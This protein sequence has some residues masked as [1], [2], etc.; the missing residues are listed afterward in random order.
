MPDNHRPQLDEGGET[1]DPKARGG[2]DFASQ[3]AQRLVVSNFF[4]AECHGTAARFFSNVHIFVGALAAGLAAVS[5]GTAFTG[6]TTLAGT[7]GLLSAASAGLLTALRPD[8]RSLCTG[9]RPQ[10]ISK[11]PTTSTCHLVSAAATM[12][13]KIVT[14]QTSPCRRPRCLRLVMDRCKT[15]RQATDQA[16][17]GCPSYVR[18]RNRSIVSRP[19]GQRCHV[20]WSERRSG[21]S[22]T[23][24]NGSRLSTTSS[25][26]GG[27]R[28]GRARLSGR[29]GA[30]SEPSSKPGESV[31][32]ARRLI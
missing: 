11:R 23:I 21:G 3:Q 15:H 24:R 2:R 19:L 5:G 22:E 12:R 1:E 6:N 27:R 9:K 17:I 32:T 10:P 16:W 4:R 30:S 18:S 26:S 7:L 14:S 25:Q 13:S 29:S 20:V 31:A 8:E 28:S